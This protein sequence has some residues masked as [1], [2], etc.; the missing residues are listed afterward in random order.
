[1]TKNKNIWILQTGEPL[2]IDQDDLRPMRGM[3]LAD[4]L[5][6]KGN[7]VTL[8]SSLF[9]HQKKIHRSHKYVGKKTHI[10]ENLALILLDSPGYKKN[11]SIR[12][13]YDHLIMSYNL[14][15]FLSGEKKQPD[16]VFIGYP[17][18]EVAFVMY[19]W[20][21]KRNIPYI[22]DVK[23]QW[24]HLI[25][26]AFSRKL[27]FIIKFLIFPYFYFA[28]KIF[29]NAN[30]ITSMSNSFIDWGR[31]F[32]ETKRNSLDR[33]LPLVPKIKPENIFLKEEA[34][35]RCNKLNIYKDKQINI[36]FIGSISSAFNF[37]TIISCAS[38]LPNN[39]RFVICGDG[40]L[41][42]SLI[43]KSKLFENIIFPGWVDDSMMRV[44]SKRS[45]YAIAPYKNIKN[46][47][48]NIP[49]KIIDYLSL[50]LPIFFSLDGE[51][52]NLNFKYNFGIKYIENSKK[53]LLEKISLIIRDENLEG[54]LSKNALNLYNKHYTYDLVYDD[55]VDLINKTYDSQEIKK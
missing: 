1:M 37:D 14:R 9:N 39:V 48:D 29:S 40:E 8:I 45:S 44:L 54:K 41:R 42:K 26:S 25:V 16:I 51:V 34:K 15:K 4:K 50:G 35:R 13:I 7:N 53:S 33:V 12:R 11:I 5:S 28:R 43:E 46:F 52:E 47:K 38:E 20:L 17:P 18:I 24:P 21:K 22:L 32:S 27:Q 30:A 10:N 2:H 23:D 3:N 19:R 6:E 49:N 31:N 36:L 55:A